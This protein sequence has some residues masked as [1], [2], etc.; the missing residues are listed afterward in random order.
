MEKLRRLLLACALDNVLSCQTGID[1]SF[2]LH[3]LAAVPIAGWMI[4]SCSAVSV[5]CRLTGVN[6]EAAASGRVIQC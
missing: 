3:C 5:E 6:L 4:L 2:C 1:W